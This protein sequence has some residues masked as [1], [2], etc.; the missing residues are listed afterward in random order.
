MQKFSFITPS[1]NQGKYI[2]RTV[3][4]VLQ[5]KNDEFFGSY[6]VYDGGSSDNT[7]E[8][9]KNYEKDI[10]WVSR[11]DDGQA[12]GVNQG[13]NSSNDE[14]IAWINSDDV[15]EKE[16]FS[17]VSKIFNNYPDIDVIYGKAQHIDENDNFINE[18]PT[19][20]F[21]LK[22]LIETCFI[23]QPACFFRRQLI[24]KYG[25]LKS[26]LKYCMD[27]ELWLRFAQNG[28]KFFYLNKV[29][30]YSRF[31]DANKTLSQKEKVHEEINYMIREKFG[32][33]NDK[34]LYALAHAKLD[35][36]NLKRNS[37]Q[38]ILNLI[39]ESFKNSVTWNKKISLTMMYYFI[40]I[41]IRKIFK[42][43]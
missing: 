10:V 36:Q 8:I 41:L 34:W 7:I 18:Y 22:G 30:A 20:E 28:A 38:Y 5:F 21:T 37:F 33:V 35:N 1:Y 24:S 23:C 6:H 19:E 11:Q 39:F 40:K 27:Y 43:K 14:I 4:S 42:F 17:E 3:K 16:H 15:Y 9:L 31:Y 29:L 32:K 25:L 13:I 26:H 12:D 2:E